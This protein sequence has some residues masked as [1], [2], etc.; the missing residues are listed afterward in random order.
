[1]SGSNSKNNNIKTTKKKKSKLRFKSGSTKRRTLKKSY[2]EKTLSS[3][4]RTK[5]KQEF[6]NYDKEKETY[7]NTWSE[8]VKTVKELGPNDIPKSKEKA[9]TAIKNY[10]NK[11]LQTINCL[12]DYSEDLKKYKPVISPDAVNQVTNLAKTTIKPVTEE[13]TKKEIYTSEG[14]TA[15]IIKHPI[16]RLNYIYN[17]FCTNTDK[18]KLINNPDE[19]KR[20]WE[21]LLRS[22]KLF[23]TIYIGFHKPLIKYKV[24]VDA[25][26]NH[27]WT[28]LKQSGDNIFTALK[29]LSNSPTK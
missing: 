4:Q 3:E 15:N 16:E 10:I 14:A 6:K 2:K 1:M 19:F 20:L 22:I 18:E 8:D 11:I 26:K 21:N 9:I 7:A 23:N 17:G 24:V 13:P 29:E 28:V 25:F 12:K 5:K 27:L